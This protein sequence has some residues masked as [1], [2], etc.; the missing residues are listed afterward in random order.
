MSC[1]QEIPTSTQNMADLSLLQMNV[2]HD[3]PWEQDSA[4]KALRLEQVPCLLD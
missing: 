2:V 1:L 3:M 4:L